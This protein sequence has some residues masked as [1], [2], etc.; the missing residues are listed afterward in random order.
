MDLA[1]ASD[2]AAKDGKNLQRQAPAPSVEAGGLLAEFSA[3]SEVAPS[4]SEEW[5]LPFQSKRLAVALMI[6]AAHDRPEDLAFVLTPDATWGFPDTRRFGQQ[7]IRADDDGR[8]FLSILRSAARRFPAKTPWRTQ[9]LRSG[10]QEL[11]R[12]GA[13]PMWSYYDNGADRIYLREVL[14]QG[15]ARIDYVGF[16]AELP[17]APINITERGDAPPLSPLT[18]APETPRTLR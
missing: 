16:F 4:E 1:P 7:S 18:P 10:H 2:E 15:R 14:Y 13:E 17:T 8:A 5:E 11:V 12:T 6:A 3:R 9:P